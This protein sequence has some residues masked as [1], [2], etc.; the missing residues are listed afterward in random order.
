MLALLPSLCV[1]LGEFQYWLLYV[2]LKQGQGIRGGAGMQCW[3]AG[4]FASVVGGW[5]G[6]GKESDSRPSCWFKT[7]QVVPC[8]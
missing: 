5:E 2:H 4:G 7:R 6:E 3:A 8:L 1:C